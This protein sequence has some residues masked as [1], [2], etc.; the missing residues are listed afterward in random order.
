M[1]NTMML[2]IS[3]NISLMFQAAGALVFA[4]VIIIALCVIAIRVLS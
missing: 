4:L 2:F 1:D 3:Q